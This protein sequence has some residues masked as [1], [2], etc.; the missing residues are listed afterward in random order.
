MKCLSAGWG[1][2]SV[3]LAL[4]LSPWAA[5]PALADDFIVYSPYV[6]ATRGEVELRG[7]HVEDV[8]AE[9]GGGAAEL[10]VS[11]GVTDWWKPEVYLLEYAQAPGSSGR[12]Q[13]YEFENTFQ[14]TPPGR[15]F[16]DFGFLASYGHSTVADVV[17][18]V[19]FGPL[20]EVTRGRFAHAVNLIW[21]KQVGSGASGS[22]EIR[23]SYAGTY[24]FSKAVQAG[25]EA[26][27]RPADSA[28]Q[29][30][31][32]LKGEWNVPGTASN[33]GYRVGVLL[34]INSAAPRQTW[35]AQLEYEF[36]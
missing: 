22:Y 33:L 7:F 36:F 31:P 3:V 21:E 6:I 35:L 17:D 4:G 25:F 20:M 13:G 1:P 24:A 2:A 34:G 14:L 26:Y 12:L 23:Y 10:S 9:Q 18:T 11:Y 29:A 27:G 19:E 32:I 8:R 5:K 30:G 15:Y 28:Y 16:A